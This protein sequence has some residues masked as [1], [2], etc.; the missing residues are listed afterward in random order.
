MKK[1]N[2]FLFLFK[3]NQ[4]KQVGRFKPDKVGRLNRK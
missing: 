4:K 3:K 1:I 2:L